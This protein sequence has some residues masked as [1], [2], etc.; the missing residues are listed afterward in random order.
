MMLARV[1]NQFG[2]RE[3]A[4]RHLERVKQMGISSLRYDVYFWIAT[5]H[6]KEK[7]LPEALDAAEEAWKISE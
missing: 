3:E 6:Y 1:L 7:R 4:M 5:V 2:D